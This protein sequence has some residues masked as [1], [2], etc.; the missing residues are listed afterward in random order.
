VQ[1][2]IPIN[3]LNRITC[4]IA[5]PAGLAELAKPAKLA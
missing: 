3:V 1:V 4:I 2:K 5:K